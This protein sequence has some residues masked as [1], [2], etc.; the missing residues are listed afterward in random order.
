MKLARIILPLMDNQYRDLFAVHQ[1]L[2]RMLLA[3]WGGYTASPGDGAWRGPDG[4]VFA[5]RVMIYEIAMELGD[6]L[7]L[8]EI[9]RYICNEAQ[10]E[11]VMIVTPHGDVDFV[12]PE[13]SQNERIARAYDLKS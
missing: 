2:K 7:K 6:V 13:M 12:R 9:A 11:S 3:A 8:R 1:A 10:Q 5:E 4:K